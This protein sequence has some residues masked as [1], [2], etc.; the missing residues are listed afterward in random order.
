MRR[1]ILLPLSVIAAVLVSAMAASG[2]TDHTD[3][4]I[5]FHERAYFSGGDA[6]Q[7]FVVHP[8]RG[9]RRTDTPSGWRT[10]NI[11]PT[12]SPDGLK[13]AF[14]GE[15]SSTDGQRIAFERARGGG[16]VFV[17]NR[18]RTR[19]RFLSWGG[20]PSW[21]PDG[22]RIAFHNGRDIAVMD[23]DGRNYRRVVKGY[24]E[25]GGPARGNG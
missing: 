23:P 9:G 18:D 16:G 3:G 19:R 6:W 7:V 21:S 20:H 11:D 12:W 22:R 10:D 15:S 2:A 5:A 8:D 1:S 17:I 4:W 13:I 25:T 14:Y 24:A